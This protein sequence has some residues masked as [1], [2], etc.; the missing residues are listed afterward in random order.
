MIEQINELLDKIRGKDI[1]LITKQ[2][3]EKMETRVQTAVNYKRAGKYEESVNIYIE[4][5]NEYPSTAFIMFLYKVIASAGYLKESAELL[6]VSSNAY[7][8][9]PSVLTR[10]FN[11]PSNMDVHR[12]KLLD[13]I[14][15]KNKLL[16]YLKSISGNPN[17]EFSRNYETMKK[18]LV[19]R[20]N[21][22]H[23]DYYNLRDDTLDKNKKK[24]NFSGRTCDNSDLS[25]SDSHEQLDK[26]SNEII[27]Q[28]IAFY[29]NLEN[30]EKAFLYNEE[31]V[32]RGNVV[33]EYN[34]GMFYYYGDGVKQDFKKA[35][36][37]FEGVSVLS[38]IGYMKTYIIESLL[39]MVEIYHNGLSGQVN[40]DKAIDASIKLAELGN[41]N[42]MA[43]LVQYYSNGIALKPDYDKALKYMSM[44]IEAKDHECML[45][46]GSW[47]MTGFLG[48]KIDIEKAIYYFKLAAENG[49]VNAKIILN[50]M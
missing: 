11:L 26:L 12:D 30:Y 38:P 23:E 28:K 19:E 10:E 16:D 17:Y 40:F 21:L 50:N 25:A 3:P 14:K 5:I 41:V 7:D 47:H 42:A 31:A 13:A 35:L 1:E 32:K 36:S 22:P 6:N 33:A 44:A 39:K 49:N 4:L 37:F 18:E 46:F 15:T 8:K 48:T 9:S 27:M 34:M 2:Y 20:F 24:V 45:Q 29:H 43:D